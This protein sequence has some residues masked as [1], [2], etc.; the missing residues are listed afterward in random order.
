ME[1]VDEPFVAVI[2]TFDK[3]RDSALRIIVI[4]TP[5][6]APGNIGPGVQ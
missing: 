4:I 6:S 1:T 3:R 5:V 2:Y